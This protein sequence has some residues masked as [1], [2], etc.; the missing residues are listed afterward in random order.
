M[1]GR[2]DHN[3]WWSPTQNPEAR[4]KMMYSRR[5]LLA[6]RFALALGFA[7]T[8]AQ[9]STVY[10]DRAEWEAASCGLAN[11]DFEG[12]APVGEFV[13]FGTPAG[14]TIG[15]V[16]FVGNSGSSF[17][18]GSVVFSALLRLGFWR[19]FIGSCTLSGWFPHQYFC[20]P[21]RGIT[22][23]GTD[24]MSFNF[25]S[26]GYG[27]TITVALSTGETFSVSTFDYPTR[28]FIGFTS[29]V[30]ITSLSFSPGGAE[31]FPELDNFAFGN[32]KC[33]SPQRSGATSEPPR[34]VK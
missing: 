20:N 32:A 5:F 19:R 27:D 18:C 23:V 2:P 8:A 13:N 6:L 28:A 29:D 10:T 12:I 3:I 34:R 15:G 25:P 31:A 30:P 22:S 14:L 33:A 1:N 4:K 21:A 9:A 26:P 7:L 24:I 16:N 11:I 17:R